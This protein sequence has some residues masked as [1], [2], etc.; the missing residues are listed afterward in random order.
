MSEIRRDPKPFGG[1]QVIFCA[2]FLQLPPVDKDGSAG[3][4]AFDAECWNKMELAVFEL[5]QNFRQSGDRTF[6]GMLRRLRVGVLMQNDREMLQK[7]R[8]VQSEQSTKLY[9]MNAAV[10]RENNQQLAALPGTAVQYL[11]RDHCSGENHGALLRNCERSMLP[12]K[13]DLKIGARVMVLRNIRLPSQCS[14]GQPPLVNGTVGTIVRFEPAYLDDTMRLW[15]MEQ[16][17]EEIVFP[18]LRLKEGYEQVMLPADAGGEVAG[19]GKYGR[20][21]LPLR[22]AWALS[23]HKSQGAT[24]DEGI[25]DL[26]GAFEEGQVYVALSRFRSLDKIS[27]VGLPPDIRVNRRAQEFHEW[28]SQNGIVG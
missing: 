23:V 26:R 9:C 22:L 13:L 1:V 3:G 25:V 27:V 18:V 28:V 2:D 6:E 17:S 8:A 19:M 12:E 14:K 21:Q 24:L 5:T 7:W 20:Q 4:F 11:K 10:D 16:R 15:A